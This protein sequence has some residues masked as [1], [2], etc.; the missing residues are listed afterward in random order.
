MAVK[1]SFESVVG[2]KKNPDQKEVKVVGAEVTDVVP[3][4]EDPENL[5]ETPKVKKVDARQ[6]LWDELT[7]KGISFK[8]NLSKAKLEALLAE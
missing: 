5:V 6:P 1:V 7:E 2:G 4:Q 3:T 8:K